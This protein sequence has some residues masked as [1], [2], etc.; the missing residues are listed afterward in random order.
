MSKSLSLSL[1]LTLS[2]SLSSSSLPPGAAWRRRP[3]SRDPS[4]LPRVPQAPVGPSLS[5][6]LPSHR[7]PSPS[8]HPTE[9]H[10]PGFRVSRRP[11]VSVFLL[12]S[13]F[14][15]H[16]GTKPESVARAARVS[17]SHCPPVLVLPSPCFLLPSRPAWPLPWPAQLGALCLSPCPGSPFF[18]LPS[19]F[20]PGTKPESASDRDA[21]SR[22]PCV[23]PS[24]GLCLSP[25]FFHPGTK[26]ESVQL[27][28]LSSLCPPV[29]LPSLPHG[30][31]SGTRTPAR[32]PDELCGSVIWVPAQAASQVCILRSRCTCRS[33]G[34]EPLSVS[35]SVSK[36]LSLSLCLT[37]SPSLSSS[38]P[39]TRG[40]LASA[41]AIEGPIPASAS[42]AAPGSPFSF[43]PSDPACLV[44]GHHLCSPGS[45][46]VCP[47]SLQAG[48]QPERHRPGPCILP[49]P[50]PLSLSP[51]PL[52]HLPPSP[53]THPPGLPGAAHGLCSLGLCVCPPVLVLAFFLPSDPACLVLGHHLCS[54]GSVHLSLSQSLP[55]CPGLSFLQ[56]WPAWCLATT[57]VA[58]V[59]PSLSLPVCPGLSFLPSFVP[60]VS[61]RP[62]SWKKSPARSS[63]RL[64]SRSSR[65]PTA[66][67]GLSQLRTESVSLSFWQNTDTPHP[68]PQ[69]RLG[70]SPLVPEPVHPRTIRV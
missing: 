11:R 10:H 12:P 51:P 19:P 50:P 64:C 9:T 35:V 33:V 43:L 47:S 63:P 3:P 13:P 5:F 23:S 55:V 26:P 24:P 21:P 57:C 34:D 30:D 44:L 41:S 67:P 56:T 45:V 16:P 46:S 68:R 60:G 31:E 1:C 40:C 4:R 54:L 7:G 62:C 25:A 22:L 36:S 38:L 6:L 48:A 14:F 37:V 2:P 20:S 8:P 42:P 70:L 29:S 52:S 58:R 69:P 28:S 59:F 15:F 53:P 61:R 49:A 32:V 39:S 18:L 17:L 27:G 65:L 66:C